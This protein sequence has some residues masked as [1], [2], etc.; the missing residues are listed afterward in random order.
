MDIKDRFF[1]YNEIDGRRILTIYDIVEI[2]KCNLLERIEIMA[3]IRQM[4]MAE[5]GQK[6]GIDQI[7]NFRS[8]LRTAKLTHEEYQKLAEIL[9]AKYVNKVVFRSG[10]EI[11]S[12]SNSYLIRESCLSAERTQM[13]IA[14]HLGITRQAMNIRLNTDK[15]T[16]EEMEKIIKFLGGKYESYFEMDGAKI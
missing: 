4:D 7:G 10:Y 1:S 2:D 9:G 13:D 8:K 16:H 12:G 5:V 14:K 3:H 15:F 11:E 6:F